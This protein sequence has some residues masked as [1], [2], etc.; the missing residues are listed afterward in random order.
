[1]L[2]LFLSSIL[3][4]R[5][6]HTTKLKSFIIYERSASR[7]PNKIPQEE[8]SLLYSWKYKIEHWMTAV[9]EE[10]KKT[11]PKKEIFS[12]MSISLSKLLHFSDSEIAFLWWKIRLKF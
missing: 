4:I 12:C 8:Q 6:T 9:Q 7:M 2:D 5:T 1:M 10:L 3:Q 11:W